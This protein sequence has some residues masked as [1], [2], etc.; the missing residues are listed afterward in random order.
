MTVVTDKE[1]A[2]HADMMVRTT[3]GDF[4]LAKTRNAILP[5]HKTGYV[6]IKREGND[7]TASA[8]LGGRTPPT[9]IGN[10]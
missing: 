1:R 10:R 9:T 5:W 2:G 3:R 6:Y 7:G 8:S 4:I